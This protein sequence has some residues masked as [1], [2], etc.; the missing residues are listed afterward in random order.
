M[1]DTPPVLRMLAMCFIVTALF[2]S[3]SYSQ[4]HLWRNDCSP[5]FPRPSLREYLP[6]INSIDRAVSEMYANDSEKVHFMGNGTTEA[7]LISFDNI[8]RSV[9]DDTTSV[10]KT[11]PFAVVQLLLQRYNRTGIFQKL[12]LE[13]KRQ[14]VCGFCSDYSLD[15]LDASSIFDLCERLGIQVDRLGSLCAAM[16]V[17]DGILMSRTSWDQLIIEVA[18]HC[19]DDVGVPDAHELCRSLNLTLTA[20]ASNDIW[21]GL[22]YRDS[23]D[24]LYTTTDATIASTYTYP[25]INSNPM[26]AVFAPSRF[27]FSRQAYVGWPRHLSGTYPDDHELR[28]PGYLPYDAVLGCF[29]VSSDLR[30]QWA[31]HRVMQPCPTC[32][33][34]LGVIL[35]PGSL[36]DPPH[37]VTWLSLN[38]SL[39]A[40]LGAVSPVWGVFFRCSKAQIIEDLN[41]LTGQD[42]RSLLLA[43]S[44]LLSHH[45][46][47][48]NTQLPNNLLSSLLHTSM[49]F[50]SSKGVCI[51]SAVAASHGL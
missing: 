22:Q 25:R 46:A 38:G 48:T 49:E 39:R 33:L 13:G 51:L 15:N 40:H 1:I 27:S 11:I 10:V 32:D 16:H 3:G 42:R 17:M 35:S 43:K 50:G 20:T 7:T 31:F 19:V 41:A 9:L 6:D 44:W 5:L 23:V 29:F 28:T 21:A 34:H 14:S 24:V 8:I 4:T 12:G 36:K 30:I 37:Q 18:E 2:W 47:A 26:V 45:N